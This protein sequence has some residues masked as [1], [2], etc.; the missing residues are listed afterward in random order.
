M[1][2]ITLCVLVDLEG[3]LGLGLAQRALLALI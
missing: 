2:P 3:F 1:M